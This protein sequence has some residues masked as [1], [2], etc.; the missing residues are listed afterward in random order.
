MQGLGHL[1]KELKKRR[2]EDTVLVIQARLLYIRG[3]EAAQAYVA[4]LAVLGGC[5]L[6]QEMELVELV[7]AA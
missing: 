7:L 2:Q 5:R 4:L 3:R 1:H 6:L